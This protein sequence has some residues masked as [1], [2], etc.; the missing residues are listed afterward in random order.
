MGAPAD[1][2]PGPPIGVAP[3]PAI[4][5]ATG[6]ALPATAGRRT[7]NTVRPGTLSTVTA[8]PCALATACTMARPSP[9]EPVARV[10]AESPR[11][12]R[13]KTRGSS[14]GGMP[15]PSSS[16]STVIHGPPAR[17]RAVTVVPGGV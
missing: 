14:S 16:M 13:S 12:N 6:N 4:R 5:V 11:A 3:G 10:R 9:V 8:P 17:T 1:A 7:V 2:P 15:G